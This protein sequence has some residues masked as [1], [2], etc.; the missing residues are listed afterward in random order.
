MIAARVVLFHIDY[1]SMVLVGATPASSCNCVQVLLV[2]V[3]RVAVHPNSTLTLRTLP[4][5]LFLL[6]FQNIVLLPMT[7]GEQC[8][9]RNETIVITLGVLVT[10]R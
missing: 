3:T 2:I 9:T 5:K 6:W 8:F 4:H 1:C 10:T 7:A